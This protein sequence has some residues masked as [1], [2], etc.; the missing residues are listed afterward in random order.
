MSFWSDAKLEQKRGYRWLVTMGTMHQWIAK[1]VTKPSITISETSHKFINHTF[2]Y[3]GR[4]E[5]NSIDMTLIDPVTQDAAMTLMLL[6]EKAGYQVPEKVATE[7][8][9]TISKL[10]GVEAV[11]KYLIQQI[12]S[13]GNPIETWTLHNPWIK[14]VSFGNLSYDDDSILSISLGIRYD[15]AY[16]ATKNGPITSMGVNGRQFPKKSP[17]AQ[18]Y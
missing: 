2:W 5:W 18:L 16:L 4:V 1:S 10:K 3:P 12:D 6:V 7:G 9:K 15:W 13:E 8:W 17:R 14:S 11:N